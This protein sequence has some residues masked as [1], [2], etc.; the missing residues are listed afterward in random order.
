MFLGLAETSRQRKNLEWKPFVSS[1]NQRYGCMYAD[2]LPE[3]PIGGSLGALKTL[4]AKLGI[5]LTSGFET[6]ILPPSK[7]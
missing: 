1:A 6:S 4:E 5:D 2:A 3:V 7:L